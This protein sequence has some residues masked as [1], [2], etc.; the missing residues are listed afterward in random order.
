MHYEL[1]YREEQS[2]NSGKGREEKQELLSMK[3]H[4]VALRTTKTKAF[5]HRGQLETHALC[6]LI[7]FLSSSACAVFS[8]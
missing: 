2:K 7:V 5:H 8:V 3:V 6:G 4:E 1:I